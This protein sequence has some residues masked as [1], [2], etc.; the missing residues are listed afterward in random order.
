M[1]STFH[2][3]IIGLAAVGVGTAI[4]LPCVHWLFAVNPAT[5][6]ATSGVPP[7]ARELAARHVQLWTDA[8]SKKRE[9]E[10]MRQSNAEWDFMGRSFL[11]WSLAEMAVR[12]PETRGQNVAIMDEIIGETIRLERERGPYFFLMNYAKARPYVVQPM[13]SLFLDSEIA[14]MLA[15]R[16]FVEERSDYK[17]LLEE[18]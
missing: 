2:R 13:R 1:K 4:W 18:R 14:L 6:Y 17:T 9:A 3:L 8:A 5:V 11:V 10:R 15:T 16:R 12:E 7:R